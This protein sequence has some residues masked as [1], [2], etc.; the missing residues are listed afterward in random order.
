MLSFNRRDAENF[1]RQWRVAKPHVGTL[2]GG[3]SLVLGLHSLTQQ[4]QIREEVDVAQIVYDFLIGGP[5]PEA[6]EDVRGRPQ[7]SCKGETRRCDLKLDN[8]GVHGEDVES[9][10]GGKPPLE[11]ADRHR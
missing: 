10:F 9:P 3:V 4:K 6:N 7:L 5:R 2:V 11:S 8:L 1:A